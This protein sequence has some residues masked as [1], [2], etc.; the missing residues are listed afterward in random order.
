[1]RSIIQ[2][3]FPES[4][5]G[6]RELLERLTLDTTSDD[7]ATVDREEDAHVE[8][9]RID[10]IISTTCTTTLQEQGEELIRLHDQ[11]TSKFRLVCVLHHTYTS[12]IDKMMPLLRPWVQRDSL[13]LVGLSDQ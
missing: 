5:R 7:E 13:V 1:M 11:R 3:F 8:D 2:E 12:D 6:W 9:D 4:A 10:A